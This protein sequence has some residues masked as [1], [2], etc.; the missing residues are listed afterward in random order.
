M[1][2]PT[3]LQRYLAQQVVIDK[4]MASILRDA[5]QEGERRVLALAGKKGVGAAVER[6]QIAAITKEL[7]KVQ[8]EL[9]GG[10]T[11]A[12]EAGMARMAMHAAEGENLLNRLFFNKIGGPIPQY[13]RAMQVRSQVAVQAYRAKMDNGISLS[14]QVYRSQAL[15]NG[16][17][18]REVRRNILLGQGWKQI[19]DGV[20]DLIHPNVPGG[21]SYA[22][23]RLGRTELN[24]AFHRAQIDQRADSPFTEGFKWVLSGSHPRPD[25]CNDYADKVHVKNGDPG[26]FA[27][28]SVPGK[29]HPNCL[30][31]LLT[32][33]K[34]DETLFK[35]F[36][37]GKYNTHIDEQIYKYAPHVSPCG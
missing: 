11:K 25:A 32:V 29:P 3:P 19:A 26:V 24:N 16:A 12:T 9:W 18:D 5:A 20:K 2:S 21:V 30:C 36:M 33:Q 22:A 23:N 6:A 15:A 17:V 28:S 14:E 27:T 1:T 31:Y 34:D 35:E 13:E 4:E 8:A 7:R 37:E 10:V